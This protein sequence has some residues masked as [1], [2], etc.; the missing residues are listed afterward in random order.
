MRR[1]TV[2][3][4]ARPRKP[5]EPT[6]YTKQS[7]IPAALAQ[8]FTV[9]RAVLGEQMTISEAARELGMARV[10]MQAVV[11]RVEAAVITAL[12]PRPTG[13]E[14]TPAAEKQLRGRVEEL[15]KENAKLKR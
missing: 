3:V 7:E 12:Q 9:I 14:P 13:P 15:E 11:H 6:S 4:M 10:N 8:R 2:I 1:P 5:N